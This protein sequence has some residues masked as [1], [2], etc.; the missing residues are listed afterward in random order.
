MTSGG[1]MDTQM[2]PALSY[3]AGPLAAGE[4]LA[5]TLV[6]RP[7]VAAPSVPAGPS[8]ARDTAREISVG[9]VALAAAIM[10]VYLLWRSPASGPI[11]AQAR[12][13]V[14]S[15]AALDANFEAGQVEEKAYHQKRKLLKQKLRA[16]LQESQEGKS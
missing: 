2:G 13:L 6:A 10:T 3:T 14:E 15:I 1:T 5:F 9:L 4:P 12:P 8:P 11:P 16:L 7:Q